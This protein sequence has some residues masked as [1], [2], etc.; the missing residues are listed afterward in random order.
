VITDPTKN[1]YQES[2]MLFFAPPEPEKKKSIVKPRTISEIKKL[3][4]FVKQYKSEPGKS[5]NE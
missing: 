2:Q 3:Q 1:R 5:L 4:T